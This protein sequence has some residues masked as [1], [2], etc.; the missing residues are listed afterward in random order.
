MRAK[1]GHQYQQAL[2]CEGC[3][4]TRLRRL[5]SPTTQPS[6]RANKGRLQRQAL[7]LLRAIQRL[8]FVPSVVTYGAAISGLGHGPAASA[9]LDFLTGEAARCYRE[10]AQLCQQRPA[11]TSNVITCSAAI[12]VGDVG[13]RQQQAL[14]LSGVMQRRAV[15]ANVVIYSFSRRAIV[16]GVM[17]GVSATAAMRGPAFAPVAWRT[18]L[19]QCVRKGACSVRRPRSFL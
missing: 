17:G 2:R 4:A 12:S 1:E 19:P 6:V 18:G 14:H 16:P 3:C 8:V 9:G 13:Q 5:R 10:T 7:H 15:G 11:I